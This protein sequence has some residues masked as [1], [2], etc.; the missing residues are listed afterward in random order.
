MFGHKQSGEVAT[1]IAIIMAA[2]ALVGMLMP[3]ITGKADT[4]IEQA[5]ESLV[6]LQTGQEVDYSAHLKKLPDGT[7]IATD[8]KATTTRLPQPPIVVEHPYIK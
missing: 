5:A 2:V 6:K 1:T 3:R 4:P 8:V 7:V